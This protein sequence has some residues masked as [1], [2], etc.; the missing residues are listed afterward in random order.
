MTDPTPSPFDPIAVTDPPS[1]RPAVPPMPASMFPR[2]TLDALPPR[3]AAVPPPRVAAD[4]PKV[5][6]PKIEAPKVELPRVEAPKVEPPKSVSRL[7]PKPVPAPAPAPADDPI[8]LVSAEKTSPLVGAPAPEPRWVKDAAKDLARPSKTFAVAAGVLSL[9]GGA[10][11]LNFVFPNLIRTPTPAAPTRTADD[12]MDAVPTRVRAQ[13][14]PTEPR[15]PPVKLPDPPAKAKRP[16]LP[17]PAK[18]PDLAPIPAPALPEPKLPAS[19]PPAPVLDFAPPVVIQAQAKE[20]AVPVI[21]PPAPVVPEVKPPTLPPVAPVVPEI[22]P[23]VPAPT[24]VPV[25]SPVPSPL[26]LPTSDPLPIPAPVVT[27]K[28]D[29]KPLPKTDPV[30]P[31]PAT[32]VD[33]PK[34]DPMPKP[35]PVPPP[36]P[37]PSPFR[38]V[39]S[40]LKPEPPKPELPK[41]EAPK[42]ELP[43]TELPK[44]E[45]P[46]PVKPAAQPAVQ[47]VTNTEAPRTDFDVDLH[48]PKAGDTYESISKQ[49]YGDAKYAEALKAFNANRPLGAGGSVQV[50]P[51]YVLRKKFTGLLSARPVP[52]PVPVEANRPAVEWKAGS[53]P[54]GY[55]TPR[56]GMTLWDVAEDVLGDRKQWQRVWDANPRLDPNAPLPAGTP[57]LLPSDARAGR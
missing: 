8:P 20:P 31:V 50:P 30:A 6:P 10:A 51:M 47:P 11:A 35:T 1:D 29:P 37:E 42:P 48:D 46:P 40:G 52:Q 49:F 27:P 15:V 53:N 56:A 41:P 33:P 36:P 5:E 3:P 26:P 38:P 4:P 22:K 55:A 45:T 43:K 24:P 32:P 21:P 54:A 17:P 39:G 2:R 7:E 44:F 12:A 16:D 14:P 28:V 19:A 34:P 13:E 25:P 23:V 18:V 9:V 57:L